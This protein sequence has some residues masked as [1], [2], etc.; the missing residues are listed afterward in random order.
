[1]NICCGRDAICMW[2]DA[3]NIIN[4]S[5]VQVAFNNLLI[6]YLLYAGWSVYKQWVAGHWVYACSIPKISFRHLRILLLLSQLQFDVNHK[7]EQLKDQLQ[8]CK[9]LIDLQRNI[10]DIDRIILMFQLIKSS[11]NHNWFSLVT[12]TI[13]QLRSFQ[14]F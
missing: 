12:F 8:I 7:I 14:H 9:S 11:H 13:Q 10:I 1:M 2:V 4:F 3:K 6:N 5:L